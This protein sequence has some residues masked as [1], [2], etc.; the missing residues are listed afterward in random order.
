MFNPN[1]TFGNP[2]NGG[3]NPNLQQMPAAAPVNTVATPEVPAASSAFPTVPPTE[4]TTTPPA[5]TVVTTPTDVT[6]PAVTAPAVQTPVEPT[7]GQGGEPNL[8]EAST[9]YLL[10]EAM[11]ANGFIPAD[12]AL[13]EKAAD[14]ASFIEATGK[15]IQKAYQAAQEQGRLEAIQKYEQIAN[16]IEFRLKGGSLDAIEHLTPFKEALSVD[17]ANPELTPDDQLQIKQV[18]INQALYVS[19]TKDPEVRELAIKGFIE[20]GSLDTVFEQS[21]NT[22]AQYVQQYEQE[23]L[24]RQKQV[25]EN[26]RLAAEK[27]Q[28]DYV[29]SIKNTIAKG[30]L[31]GI[32]LPTNEAAEINTKIFGPKSETIEVTN[33]KGQVIAQPVT[34]WE[35]FMHNFFNNPEVQ[36]QAFYFHLK[37]GAGI[38]NLKQVAST[39]LANKIVD[40]LNNR[41]NGNAHSSFI[42]QQDNTP[43]TGKQPEFRHLHTLK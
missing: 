9:F 34:P 14:A 4:P 30:N 40:Q 43:K 1:Q 32:T 23:D 19:G 22:I 21:K 39:E 25:I 7:G 5:N 2:G 28:N 16:E 42:Q 10:G 11:K 20:K 12:F 38:S 6:T 27:A 8:S 18:I 31:G 36:L 13:D 3:V 15:E 29:N 17:I 33:E 24:N 35:K 26:Q 41:N 37:G